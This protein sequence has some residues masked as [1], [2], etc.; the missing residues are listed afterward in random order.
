MRQHFNDMDG[1]DKDAEQS[2]SH[3]NVSAKKVIHIA[4]INL[5]RVNNFDNHG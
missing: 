3:K 5:K 4:P 1:K 2:R